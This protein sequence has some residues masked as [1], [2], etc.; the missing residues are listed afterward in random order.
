MPYLSKLSHLKICGHT[1]CMY[2]MWWWFIYWSVGEWQYCSQVVVG[3]GGGGRE[4]ASSSS[5][6][7]LFCVCVCVCV[8]A[9]VCVCAGK[10]TKSFS[11]RLPDS[12]FFW[13]CSSFLIFSGVRFSRLRREENR[14]T[15]SYHCLL[16]NSNCLATLCRIN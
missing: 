12:S 16:Y 4:G 15:T 1:V 13:R 3:G 14:S 6:S 2:D 11:S 7:S 9:Y 8:H 10:L 5:S